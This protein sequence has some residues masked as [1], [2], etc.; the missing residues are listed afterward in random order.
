MF[1]GDGADYSI[2]AGD[3]TSGV[4]GSVY[5]SSGYSDQ[6]S[7]GAVDIQTMNSGS[8]GVSGDVSISTGVATNGNSGSI[9]LSTGSYTCVISYTHI[10]IHTYTYTYMYSYIHILIHS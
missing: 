10:L 9:L 4:G 5:V 7:S 1:I 8:N 6:G 2:K 3:T